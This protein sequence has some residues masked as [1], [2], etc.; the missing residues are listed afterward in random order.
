MWSGCA[1]QEGRKAVLY[2][3]RGKQTPVVPRDVC[4]RVQQPPFGPRQQTRVRRG[5]GGLEGRQCG[6]GRPQGRHATAG[7]RR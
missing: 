7:R 6:Q 4:R 2:K 3:G 1:R 5:L